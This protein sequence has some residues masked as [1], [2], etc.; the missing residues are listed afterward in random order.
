MT[1]RPNLGI[2]P[3]NTDIDSSTDDQRGD[4]AYLRVFGPQRFTKD[5]TFGGASRDGYNSYHLLEAG[6]REWLILALDWRASDEGIRWVQGVID[7]HSKLPVILTTHEL[8]GPEDNGQAAL[9]DYGRQLWD[10]LIRRND[11]IFLTLNGHF[12][13]PARTVRKR[14]GPAGHPVPSGSSPRSRCASRQRRDSFARDADGRPVIPNRLIG[15]RS[16]S[17]LGPRRGGTCHVVLIKVPGHAAQ[18]VPAVVPPESERGN[19]A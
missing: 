9:S 5:P 11:Q 6:G 7:A 10:K 14:R 16:T 1:W 18:A 2:Q 3:A 12:W 13:P 17:K 15:D 19:D 4:T 8:V